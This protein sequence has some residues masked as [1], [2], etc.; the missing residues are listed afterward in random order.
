MHGPVTPYHRK[1]IGAK[2]SNGT[3][4]TESRAIMGSV[5][6]MKLRVWISCAFVGKRGKEA[7]RQGGR[8]FV[9]RASLPLCLKKRGGAMV[10]PP[11]APPLEIDF[12]GL[13]KIPLHPGKEYHTLL[14]DETASAGNPP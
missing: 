1:A 12:E 5:P 2:E 3:G 11:K 4:S 10:E 13:V 8:N 14:R 6:F 7:G 9:L